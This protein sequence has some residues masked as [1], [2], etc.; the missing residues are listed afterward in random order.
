MIRVARGGRGFVAGDGSAFVPWGL[1][2]DRSYLRGRDVLLEELLD[3]DPTKLERDFEQAR[4]LGANV[5]R[6]FPQLD[7]YLPERDALRES[8]LA[9]LDEAID[10]AGRHELRVDLTGLTMIDSRARPAWLV[11]AGDEQIVA[12]HELFWTTLARRYAGDARIFCFNLQNEPY[13]NWRNAPV[14]ATGCAR[15]PEGKDYCYLTPHLKDVRGAWARW[16]RERYADDAALSEAWPDF[17]RHREA[18]DAPHLPRRR[19]PRGEPRRRDYHRFRVD[20]AVAWT[21]RMAAAIRRCDRARL[22]TTGLVPQCV[23]PVEPGDE[24]PA[25]AG[26]WAQALAPELDFLCVH[27]YPTLVSHD[28]DS[29]GLNLDWHEMALASLRALRKPVVV[30]EWR[31]LG[32][33]VERGGI[34]WGQWFDAFMTMSEPLAGGWCSFYHPLLDDR[35]GTALSAN[36]SAWLERFAARARELE[37]RDGGLPAPRFA[38]TLELDWMELMCS[39]AER[40][41]ALRSY[42]ER[43]AA[44]GRPLRV[45]WRE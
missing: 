20:Y 38:G 19:G 28:G 44:A 33:G 39:A 12:A 6:L 15:M 29:L 45:R 5:I 3:A 21:R 42:R 32:P 1:N 26:Y 30:E 24:A 2:Y 13:V 40:T 37:A 18:P 17:P 9:K 27:L 41:Q 16:V 25:L 43:R 22:I 4:G 35:P 7:R 36:Y 8:E 11:Q 10:M 31:A 34:G 14:H 23:M